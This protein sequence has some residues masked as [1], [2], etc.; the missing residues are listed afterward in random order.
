MK[1][2]PSADRRFFGEEEHQYQQLS[3]VAASIYISVTIFQDH[4]QLNKCNGGHGRYRGE[5][6][7][8]S[9]VA[10]PGIPCSHGQPKGLSLS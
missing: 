10:L 8:L 9:K 7:N 3:I 6:V 5:E 1:K 4:C 2:I